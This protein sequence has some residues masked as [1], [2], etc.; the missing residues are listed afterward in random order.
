VRATVSDKI[1][2]SMQTNHRQISLWRFLLRILSL[3]L[4]ALAVW[5]V[6]Q[7]WRQFNQIATLIPDG[8]TIAGLPVGG[9][10][11]QQAEQALRQAYEQPVDLQYGSALIQITPQQA[12]FQLDLDAMLAGLDPAG[13]PS[14]WARFWR[15][16]KGERPAAVDIPLKYA[17]SEGTLRQFLETQIVTRYDQPATPAHPQ[18]GSVKFYPGQP[19]TTLDV[20]AAVPL[21]EK[22]FLSS[23][24]Q[25]VILPTQKQEPL[26]PDWENLQTLLKQTI[27]IDGFKGLVGVY[28]HDLKT[29]E[30]IHF[31][32]RPGQELPVDPDVAFTASSIIKIPIL[33]SVFR[34]L[35][36]PPTG[37]VT[38]LLD[39]MIAQSSNEAADSLM[40]N[41]LD[42]VRGPL[43]VSEDM[44][45]I[46]LKNT[47]LAGYFALG[48]P[49]LQAFKT[50]ANQR[51]D[52]NTDPDPYSQTTPYDIGQLLVDI[53]QCANSGSGPLIEAFGKDMTQAKC[54]NIIDY[55]KK[56][57]QPY[58]I[59]AG[60]PEGTSI[61]HKHGYGSYQG[62]IHTIGDAALVFTPG[63][64]YVL[65]IYMDDRD[66]LL[67]DTANVLIAH[68]SSA[69]YNYYNVY[70]DP[71]FSALASS[72]TTAP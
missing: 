56:D 61:A 40:K 43:I 14:T 69:V 53:Y 47:F 28:L 72:P 31:A 42:Q 67:W 7:Q 32:V 5:I 1:I 20:A 63:G 46:G 17:F 54:Q 60:L 50:P 57:R 13:E 62:I 2:Q 70:T 29:G 71:A 19:G 36:G 30:E 37:D 11:Y 45:A 58:L 16:L 48:S 59:T 15:Y 25:P 38:N 24:A 8:S 12:G 18:V 68:L 55:L 52:V 44:Q 4:L 33:V 10:T 34:H 21:I 39:D 65:S 23:R 66:L 41:V 27:T 9:L 35:S 26:P 51:P 3:V 64:D 49:L 6:N 22:A